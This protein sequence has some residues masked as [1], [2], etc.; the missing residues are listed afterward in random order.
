MWKPPAAQA[1]KAASP[2]TIFLYRYRRQ[3][4][5]HD[6][7]MP[8][9]GIFRIETWEPKSGT[10]Q[11]DATLKVTKISALTAIGQI[12]GDDPRKPLCELWY[13]SSGTVSLWMATSNQGGLGGVPTDI[14]NVPVGTKFS[15]SLKY[16]ANK[17]TATVDGTS[18]TF[19]ADPSW[20]NTKL[21]FFK[22]GKYAQQAMIGSPATSEYVTVKFYA[23][24]TSHK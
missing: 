10:H 11:L 21:F 13:R 22:A 3:R 9:L 4:D 14:S 2:K 24:S 23:L 7:P 6:V 19:T 20:E 5:G 8:R 16:S 17:V 18:K 12:V 15:Y 1:L